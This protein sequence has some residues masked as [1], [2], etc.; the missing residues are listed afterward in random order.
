M[1][2]EYSTVSEVPGE[3]EVIQEAL[4]GRLSNAPSCIDI[5]QVRASTWF[6]VIEIPKTAFQ[7]ESRSEVNATFEAVYAF[8]LDLVVTERI[9][10]AR[11]DTI[12]VRIEFPKYATISTLPSGIRPTSD[13]EASG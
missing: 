10:P 13:T 7:L 11:P 12:R 8:R 6:E 9:Y 3:V 1:G 2:T 4:N 5:E